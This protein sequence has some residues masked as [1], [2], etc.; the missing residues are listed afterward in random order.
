MRS[1]RDLVALVVEQLGSMADRVVF[2]GGVI[3]PFLT[4]DP[5]AAPPRPTDDVDLFVPHLR[6]VSDYF[7]FG[8]QLR[9]HGFSEDDREGAPRCRW[10]VEGV[11]VDVMA[12]DPAPLG[13]TNVWYESAQHH[14][15]QAQWEG[16]AIRH[17]DGAHFC[18]TK[19]EAFRSRAGGDFLHRDMEDFVG[20]LDERE[21]LVNE[22]AVSPPAVRAFLGETAARLVSD[23]KF[24]E[25]SKGLFEGDAASQARHPYMIE[26]LRTLSQLASSE[27]AMRQDQE[28]P[29][30]TGSPL[31]PPVA[32]VSQRIVVQSSNLAWVAYHSAQQALDVGFSGGA[33]YRYFAVPSSVYSGLL[34]AFSKGQYMHVWVSNRYR[35][36]RIG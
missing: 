5:A 30:T 10:V 4:T 29:T 22:I 20:L 1:P 27:P 16:Q 34:A 9:A 19:L 12:V 15:K 8:E 7:L 23:A 14:V 24:L 33:T 28:A 26:K 3:R 21:T 31:D 25:V 2:V 32:T 13:M 11:T 36:Q 35:Y 18:A 6:T 17:I